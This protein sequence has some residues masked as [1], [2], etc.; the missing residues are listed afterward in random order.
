MCIPT[1]YVTRFF[2]IYI[3]SFF[4]SHAQDTNKSISLLEA[5]VDSLVETTMESEHIPGLA[6]IVIKDGRTLLK[7]GYGY[8]S[9]GEEIRTVDPDS[10]IFRIGSI[11][12]TFTATALLQLADRKKI[13]L[14][15]DVN[16]YL[17]SFK[18]SSKYITPIT[19]AHL[20]NHSAG[21][22][23]LRGRVVYTSEEAI[24]LAS[25]LKERLIPI[26]EPGIISSYSSFGIALAGLLVEE[27]S[28]LGLEQYL[29][30]NIWDPLGMTMTSMWLTDEIEEHVSW[31]Y[32]YRNGINVPMPWEYYHTYPASEINS[33]VTDMGK[34][35]QM[36][37]DNGIYD[38]KRI[39]SQEL[40]KEMKKQ[41]LTVHP[42]VEAFGYGFYEDNIHGFR[43]IAHGGDMLGYASYL[44]LVPEENLGVFVIHHHE[45]ARLRYNVSNAILEHFKKPQKDTVPKPIETKENLERFAGHYMWS[46]YCHTCENSWRPDREK[47]VVNDDNTFTIMD[48]TYYQVEPLLF[49]SFDGERTMG[50]VENDQGEI[51]YMSLGSS[52]V[53][54]KVD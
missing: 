43:T 42:E 13:G 38:D 45:G 2:F 23:E 40:S 36:H 29:K 46:T 20:L 17:T 32:E 15:T 21:F 27:V 41:Q 28:G 49:K 14:H 1:T 5:K 31:G 9:L 37:L 33:T 50:F 34:Y 35:M 39:L 26:R 25:F 12:K 48:R 7:K 3:I 30:E 11:T 24:P 10:T 18:L 51:S 52:N 4:F 47:L 53:F 6:F 8:T 54:E 22:D 16:D 19:A 44:T